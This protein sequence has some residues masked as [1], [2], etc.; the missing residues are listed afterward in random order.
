[1]SVITDYIRREVNQLRSAPK[2][3]RL[4][5]NL[6]IRLDLGSGDKRGTDGWT[7]VDMA[8]D[9]D[10]RWDLKRGIPLPEDSVET[11]YSSHMF[12]HIPFQRLLRL[13][14]ECHRVLR[15]GGRVLVCVPNARLYVD[16][17]VEGREAE[18]AENMYAPALTPTGSKIDVLNYTAYMSEAHKYMFDEENLPNT[19]R[20]GGFRHAELR[21]FDP[22]IDYEIYRPIS[23]YAVAKK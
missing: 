2:W 8:G 20:A 13:I 15:P 16:A 22:A 14:G 17:Y 18:P 6:S 7:T 1:M 12:E 5:N 9:P 10:I 21:D 11:I 4:A 23:L 19:L 3:R